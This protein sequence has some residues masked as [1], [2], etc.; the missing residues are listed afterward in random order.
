VFV[1]KKCGAFGSW[2]CMLRVSKLVKAK[3]GWF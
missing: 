3:N 2:V 1:S